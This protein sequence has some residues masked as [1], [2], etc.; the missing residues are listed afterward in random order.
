MCMY[1]CVYIHIYRAQSPLQVWCGALTSAYVC[2]GGSCARSSS[3]RRKARTSRFTRRRTRITSTSSKTST[4][5]LKCASAS[6]CTRTPRTSASRTRGRWW[7]RIDCRRRRMRG[8]RRMR[9]GPCPLPM[10]ASL[11]SLSRAR[12]RARALPGAWPLALVMS[13]PAL[14][15]GRGR[16]DA[17]KQIRNACACV[18]YLFSL[19]IS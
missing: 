10:P 17:Q 13:T 1:V 4:P 18:F 5:T 11:V 7:R 6:T 19:R 16:E 3:K 12:A 2:A 8:R 15:C 14:V 9:R